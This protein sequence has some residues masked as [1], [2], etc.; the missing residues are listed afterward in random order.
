M[1]FNKTYTK[2]LH[3]KNG[4]VETELEKTFVVMNCLPLATLTHMAVSAPFVLPNINQIMRDSTTPNNQVR[5]T[6]LDTLPLWRLS[7][8]VISESS[9]LWFS[10][11]STVFFSSDRAFLMTTH[12]NTTVNMIYNRT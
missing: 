12:N 5:M 2:E 6:P 11:P 7:W 3:D 9:M 1:K 10:C 8:Q 4:T